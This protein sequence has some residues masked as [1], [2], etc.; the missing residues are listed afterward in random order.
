V[1]PR[2]SREVLRG[3]VGETWLLIAA[4]PPRATRPPRRTT[5]IHVYS[6]HYLRNAG[7]RGDEQRGPLRSYISVVTVGAPFTER[8]R[9]VVATAAADPNPRDAE[10]DRNVRIGAR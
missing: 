8:V 7:E 10:A 4:A 5:A 3:R 1:S 9:A 6:W 2:S